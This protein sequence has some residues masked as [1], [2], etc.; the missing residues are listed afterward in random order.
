[1][2]TMYLQRLVVDYICF[3]KSYIG[4]KLVS[5]SGFCIFGIADQTN[6]DILGISRCVTHEFELWA[7]S[8]VNSNC[9][10]ENSL[11]PRPLDA[12]VTT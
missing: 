4:W 10:V 5:V 11:T 8:L 6:Y 7:K 12:P 9:D 3:E 2:G 1:M